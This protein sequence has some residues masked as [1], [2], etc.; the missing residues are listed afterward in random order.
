M[1]TA[2]SGAHS[3]LRSPRG[4]IVSTTTR[5]AT[6]AKQ[7]DQLDLTSFDVDAVTVAR[8]RRR[9]LLRR[10]HRLCRVPHKRSAGAPSQ[11][12][13]PHLA[14]PSIGGV[15]EQGLFYC[16][17]ARSSTGASPHV[18]ASRPPCPVTVYG[19]LKAEAEK[20]FFRIRRCCLDTPPDKSTDAHR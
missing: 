9:I 18:Q 19:K 4:D 2:P 6:P 17:P 5:R 20:A 3:R 10:H 7:C 12:H 13:R 1:K 11:C 15:R 16:R 14:C 8:G